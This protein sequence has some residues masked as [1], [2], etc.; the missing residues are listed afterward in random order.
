MAQPFSNAVI[1]NS[2]LELINRSQ[3]GECI[4]EFTRIAV[5]DGTYTK[6]EK[7][8]ETLA[9]M[10]E[11]KNERKSYS[12]YAKE[13]VD[14][15]AI[16]LKTVISN[17]DSTEERPL[18]TKGFYLNEIAVFA[19]EEGT[20]DEVLYSVAVVTSTTG[21]FMPAYNG[22]NPAQIIQNYIVQVSNANNTQIVVENGIYA[23]VDQVI[24]IENTIASLSNTY[25]KG[26]GI[27]FSISNGILCVTYDDGTEE[28]V[29]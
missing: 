11:L 24:S 13:K 17:Y 7:N 1:T 23:T 21:D 18:I 28:G 19:R 4:I 10:T 2:G 26:V 22:Y 16:M 29:D 12:I 25:A 3:L 9:K 6:A 14:E 5:G 8:R 27:E 20:E 15:N